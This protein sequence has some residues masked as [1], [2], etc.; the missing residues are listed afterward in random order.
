MS[1][2]SLIKLLNSA[3]SSMFSSIFKSSWTFGTDEM[4]GHSKFSD[5]RNFSS[6]KSTDMEEVIFETSSASYIVRFVP[7]LV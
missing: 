2:I 6:S 7:I 1:S 5:V 3:V 4:I